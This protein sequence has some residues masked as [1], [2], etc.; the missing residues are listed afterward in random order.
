M[1]GIRALL[2]SIIRKKLKSI[3]IF[4]D[5]NTKSRIVKLWKKI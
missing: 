4:K 3:H 2:H 1:G 5:I